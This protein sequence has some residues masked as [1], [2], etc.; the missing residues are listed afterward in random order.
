[1]SCGKVHDQ[2]CPCTPCH[3]RRVLAREA[4][5]REEMA[6][7][8][9]AIAE[10]EPRPEHWRPRPGTAKA[11]ERTYGASTKRRSA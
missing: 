3:V 8:D 6:G 10:G 1:M 9:G 7:R 2:L 4:A 5:Y 11:I